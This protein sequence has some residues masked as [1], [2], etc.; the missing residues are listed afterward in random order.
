MALDADR[1]YNQLRS[2]V[3]TTRQQLLRAQT[4]MAADEYSYAE[5][6]SNVADVNSS[7]A[8]AAEADTAINGADGAELASYLNNRLIGVSASLG[9]WQTNFGNLLS[10]LL[11]FNAT[12]DSSITAIES[13]GGYVQGETW[14]LNGDG[15]GTF[16]P[17]VFSSAAT[18]SL[19]TDIDN[20]DAAYQSLIAG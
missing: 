9:T 11:A 15:T 18:A 13:P 19:Q 10:A 5:F 14:V 2:V 3:G 17:R 20:I 12:I 7:I 1:L 4:R 6:G 16:T 8:V